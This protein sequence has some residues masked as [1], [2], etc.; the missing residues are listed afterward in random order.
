MSY[1]IKEALNIGADFLKKA[2]IDSSRVD[3][4]VLMSEILSISIEDIVINGDS[5]IS[6]KDFTKF[7]KMI[8]R[9]LNYEPIAYMLEKKEFYGIDFSVNKNV[10]IPR[11]DSE[12]LI[13]AV[14]DLYDRDQSIS[15]LEFGVG[16]GCLVLTILKHMPNSSAIAVDIKEEAMNVAKENYNQLELKN[17][18]AFLVTDWNKM[19]TDTKF[20]LIISNPPYVK[21]SDIESLQPDVKNHEPLSALE[22]GDDGLNSYRELAP[23]LYKMMHEDSF[24]LL[25]FGENQHLKVS[26]IMHKHNIYTIKHLKDLGGRVRCVLLRR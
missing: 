25:E 11:P 10:L 14:L 7:I 23:I 6:D 26:E 2:G 21:N 15:V 9:R 24:A 12:V 1:S 18:I 22:G 4:R 17:E 3:S 8:K 13:D 19:D 16:S 5:V 20:D